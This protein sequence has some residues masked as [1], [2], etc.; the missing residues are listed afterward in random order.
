ML[1]TRSSVSAGV[2]TA[3]TLIMSLC[4][5]FFFRDYGTKRKSGKIGKF[6]TIPFKP[7]AL[8]SSI[9]HSA[10]TPYPAQHLSHCL[11]AHSLNDL[12]FCRIKMQHRVS[13]K[14]RLGVTRE[15]RKYFMLQ[16][17]ETL[18]I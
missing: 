6:H 17:K 13:A 1:S 2:Y 11:H 14:S 18:F 12:Q 9:L 5:F 15:I 8:S 10:L 3:R 4:C 7:V 16:V